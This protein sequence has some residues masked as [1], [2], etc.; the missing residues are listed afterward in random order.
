M[1]EVAFF[2]SRNMDAA[3]AGEIFGKEKMPK[4]EIVC[5]FF[6]GHAVK[7]CMTVIE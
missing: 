2:I 1:I 5:R 6:L 4:G 7:N 3:G